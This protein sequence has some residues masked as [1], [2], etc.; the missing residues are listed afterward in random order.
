MVGGAVPVTVHSFCSW[1]S[2][3]EGRACCVV[4]G[5]CCVV[6]G[7]V[8]VTLHTFSSWISVA[9][10]ISVGGGA[11]DETS[12]GLISYIRLKPKS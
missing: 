10:A 8:P 11:C 4:G 3:D 12:A 5:A 7:A 6:G 2:V 9:V 1:I